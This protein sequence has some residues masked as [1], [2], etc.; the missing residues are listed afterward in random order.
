[1]VEMPAEREDFERRPKLKVLYMKDLI[2]NTQP[3]FQSIKETEAG[4]GPEAIYVNRARLQFEH[5]VPY[6]PKDAEGK[7]VRS[8]FGAWFMWRATDYDYGHQVAVFFSERNVKKKDTEEMEWQTPYVIRD[9]MNHIREVGLTEENWKKFLFEV[10]KTSSKTGAQGKWYVRLISTTADTPGLF[11][12]PNSERY[13]N[14]FELNAAEKAII[15][16]MNKLVE[17]NGLPKEFTKSMFMTTFI[18]G[19]AGPPTTE[20]RAASI[21]ELVKTEPAKTMLHPDIVKF[22]KEHDKVAS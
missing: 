12:D 19:A 7:V 14:V 9:L 5:P 10:G 4:K 20:K 8:K 22:V 2:G 17:K 3:G 15:D 21:W 18:S 16:K 11:D 6:Q 13:K 1:M